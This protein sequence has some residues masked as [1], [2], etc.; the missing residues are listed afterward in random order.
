[1]RKV[2][3]TGNI[4]SGKSIV[5]RIFSILGVPVYNADYQAKQIMSNIDVVN[6]IVQLFGA[7]ILLDSTTINRAALA[8][9]VFEN[10]SKLQKLNNL[11]HPLVKADFLKWCSKYQAFPYVI[12]EAAILFESGFNKLFDSTILVQ[13][14]ESICI[15]RVMKRDSV[16]AEDVKARMKNQWSQELK[17]SLSD[18]V[19]VNDEAT[20]LIPQVLHT[21]HELLSLPKV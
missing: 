4:G 14:P 10:P 3:L 9:I 8:N 17:A 21:H 7:K 16:T 6:Q 1:M 11:I 18:Y 20:M 12:Q 13:A 5:A 2:G 15:A 19:I